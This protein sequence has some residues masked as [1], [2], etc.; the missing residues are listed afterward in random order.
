MG[1]PSACW[2][3]WPCCVVCVQ[4]HS[5]R[6]EQLRLERLAEQWRSQQHGMHMRQAL[7]AEL[8]LRDAFLEV[9]QVG[10]RQARRRVMRQRKSQGKRCSK[11]V[12]R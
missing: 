11:A 6:V 1:W 7:R 12:R 4:E 5:R 2:V 9:L 3:R 10:G 8:A